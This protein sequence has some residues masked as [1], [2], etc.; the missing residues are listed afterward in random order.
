M[1]SDAK[2]LL[3]LQ[4]DVA[5]LTKSFDNFKQEMLASKERDMAQIAESFD[6]F[7]T[8]MLEARDREIEDLKLTVTN[9]ETAIQTLEDQKDNAEQY[10][11]KDSIILTGPAV[12]PLTADENTRDHVVS[13]IQ[14]KLKVPITHTD[15]STTH[16]LG[17]IRRPTPGTS[18]RRNIYVKF[19]RRDTKKDVLQASKKQAKNAPLIAHESLTEK[20]RNMLKSLQSMKKAFPER[21]KGCTS[22]DG[23][24]YAFTPPLPGQTRDH[25]HLIA[26]METLQYFCSKFVQKP[27][28]DFLGSFTA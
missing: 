1:S 21:V 19:V 18:E 28:Q 22:M 24:L 23:K 13:L 7:K 2:I 8:D 20:R 3:K 6:K 9:F 26:N 16:R 5:K 12:G 25:R 15:I 27:L 4:Q 17:P 11:R 14:D 10:S